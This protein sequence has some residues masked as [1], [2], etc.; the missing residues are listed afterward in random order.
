MDLGG[1]KTPSR[2]IIAKVTVGPT[3]DTVTI[4]LKGDIIYYFGVPGCVNSNDGSR[5]GL[6]KLR[7]F[8]R[9]NGMNEFILFLTHRS[10]MEG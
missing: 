6:I 2:L 10:A 8:A 9:D 4:C 3:S 1:R 7:S 5:F